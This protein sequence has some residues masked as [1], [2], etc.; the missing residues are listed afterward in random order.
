M[1][2]LWTVILLVVLS[3]W[4][5]GCETVASATTKASTTSTL[6]APLNINVADVVA[7]QRLR[8]IGAIKAQAIVDHRQAHGAFASVD[9]LLEVKGIGKALLQR[10]REL[11]SVD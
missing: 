5:L 11:L 10:N 7:L 1:R 3:P 9:E 2:L 6:Q 8:G 4:A